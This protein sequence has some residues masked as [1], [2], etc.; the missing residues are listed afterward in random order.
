MNQDGLPKSLSYQP[1]Y[2]V[3]L[4]FP[5]EKVIRKIERA[6]VI[7]LILLSSALIV[8]GASTVAADDSTVPGIPTG[9]TATAGNG[10]VILAW[11]APDSDGGAAIDYYIVYQD[12]VEVNQ[13][14]STSTTIVDLTNGQ[15]YTFVVAAH[16]SV[17][18]GLSSDSIDSTPYTVPNA[19]TGYSALPGNGQVTL[20]WAA[21]SFD[22][23]AAIDYYI[24]YQDGDDVK[25]VTSTSTTITGLTN[26][27]SYSFAVAAHNLAGVGALT[28]AISTT[29]FSVPGTPTGLTA[30]A[31]NEQVGLAWNAPGSDGGAA[32]DYY[33]VYQDDDDVKHVTSTSTTI[34]YLENGRSFSFAVAA[35]NTAGVGAQTAAVSSTPFTVPGTPT[36]LTATAGN[37]QVVLAWNTPGSDG[38]AAID[39]YVVYQD[40]VDVKHITS[41]STTIS[42]L[43]NGRSY[44]FRVAAHNTAGVGALTPAVSST[45]ITAPGAPTGLTATAGNGQVVLAWNTPGSDG[46][47]EIEYYVVYQ[48]SVDVKHV[49]STSTTITGLTNGHSYSFMVAAYNSIVIGA[50]S[51]ETT[52]IPYTVPNAPT[53]YSAVPGNG[54]VV[55]DWVAPTFDGGRPIDYYVVYQDSVDVKHVT[56]TSTTISGLE[57]GIS[58]SFT[59]AAH[60]L[61]GNGIQSSVMPSTPYTIPGA[62]TALTAI[63]GSG[64]VTLSWNAPSFNGGAAIDYYVVYQDSVD[65]KHVTSTST[66]IIGLE[67]GRSYSF[68]V[69]AHNLAGVGAQTPAIGT[70]PLTVPGAPTG[71][72]ATAGNEQVGLS[73]SEPSNG[74]AAIDYYVVYQDTVDVKHVTSTSTTISG[75]TNG[76]SYTFVVAAHNSVGTGPNSDSIDPTPYTAPNAPTGNTA[77]PGSGQVTLSWTA[78]SFDGGATIDHYIVYQDGVALPYQY[79][80][81]MTVITGLVN[82]KTYNFTV[83]AHNLAGNGIQS[84]V[85]PSTPYTIPGAP[86]ALT[87]VFGS[88]QVTLSW[89][90]P[91]D[92]G[93]AAIDYYIVYQDG[94]ALTD[95]ATD[96]MAVISGLTNGQ[97]YSF[98]VVAHNIAGISSMSEPAT[99]K[100]Y[101]TPGAPTGFTAVAGNAK[102]VLSWSVP[103][104]DGGSP[105]DY[106]VVYQNGLALPGHIFGLTV[107]VSSLV[108]GQDYSFTVS[109]HNAAGLGA[110]SPVI[111]AT[112]FTVPGAPT[113]FSG[114]AGN[115]NVTLSWAPPSNLNGLP[116]YGYSVYRGLSANSMMMIVDNTSQRN[117][118]DE[119]LTN[120]LTYFYQ[121]VAINAA[122]NGPAAALSVEP[123]GVASP[124][125]NVR[126]ISGDTSA[127]LSW[128]APVT[129][130]GYP[131]SSYKI[132]RSD[133]GNVS[134]LVGSVGPNVLNFV[135]GTTVKGKTYSYFVEASNQYGDSAPSET[136]PQIHIYSLVKIE[137]I[138]YATAAT[139][140][141]SIKLTAHVSQVKDGQNISGL[142]VV[143]QYSV[144]AGSTWKSISSRVSDSN[145]NCTVE[146]IPVATGNFTIKATWVGNDEY[147]P[148]VSTTNL[149]VTSYDNQYLT[150]QSNSTISILAFDSVSKA[151]S[152]NVNGA[153]G[154]SGY[155]RIAVSKGLVANGSDIRISMDGANISYTL[156]STDSAWLLYFTYHH[157]AH[158]IVA[159]LNATPGVIIKGE[160]SNTV[161]TDLIFV[162][163][164]LIGCAFS[165][166]LFF[167]RMRKDKREGDN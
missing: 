65:V 120:G 15:S 76:Q 20:S 3:S 91:G 66:T 147:L 52:S 69:A 90:P 106:F 130:G 7:S 40:S 35:H 2:H 58:Y 97:A 86:T 4:G 119:G 26:G 156:S 14:A 67:N 32:I 113:S 144:T 84:S 129:N 98:T 23:G 61:A 107:T 162:A 38:G 157:S 121:V 18:T 155:A 133:P 151:L 122:G 44:S 43:E 57:N 30:T 126:V 68:A 8:F 137:T 141:Y 28:S 139:P 132:F 24:V 110:N 39:Y 17:G 31:G 27:R 127:I 71:L 153:S 104:Y 16:N 145:G 166:L 92:N 34:S 62:P 118:L 134:S 70:T 164:F 46:G 100:P 101:T 81:P 11:N 45:P 135:D 115:Q 51:E 138:S 73:W 13:V 116:L 74:G 10:Q 1:I 82:G 95:H 42:G 55:L 56:S 80:G 140:A 63:F 128:Q 102:V 148:T 9:L 152:F 87:A 123:L 79:S 21:P 89:A 163:I 131:L 83:A 5:M 6:I 94:I 88:G 78:P 72:T 47:A 143:F 12:T 29:P 165:A 53:G 50:Q 160:S 85:M 99:S 154:T 136:T 22:G 125:R 146:W 37:G 111:Y 124:P 75:L 36:G 64:Q 108:N 19:P 149:A 60:N 109:A 59:L 77:V 142:G 41:T 167:V 117:F 48:D 112:P 33:I 161:N 96:P 54:Q 49:T 93:G 150:V 158:H 105:I 103:A 25:H 114:I 159:D